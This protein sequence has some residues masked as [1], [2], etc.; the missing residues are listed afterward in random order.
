MS[1]SEKLL[2]NLKSWVVVSVPTI[3]SHG[4]RSTDH[5]IDVASGSIRGN[6]WFSVDSAYAGEYAWHWSRPETGYPLLARV[7]VRSGL[8]AVQ[9]PSGLHFPA[10]LSECFP[11]VPA[12]YELSKHF[13]EVLASHLIEAFDESV[14]AYTFS[15]HQEV[16]IASCEDWVFNAT[17]ETLPPDKESYMQQL[18]SSRE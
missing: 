5:G 11:E 17:F 10:F 8:Q 2:D 16:L 3:L 7:N 15:D 18:Q 6:K 1:L 13:Q 14:S 9:R 12:G 4:C